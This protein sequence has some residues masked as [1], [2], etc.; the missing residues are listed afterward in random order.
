MVRNV[1][2]PG[3]IVIPMEIRKIMSI[4]I[5]DPLEI[6]K[7]NNQIT[8]RKYKYSSYSNNR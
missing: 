8:L 1:N 4:N 3:R 7:E 2:Q 5:R 6:A